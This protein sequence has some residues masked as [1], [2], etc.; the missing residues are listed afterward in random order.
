MRLPAERLPL[1]ALLFSA[2]L[3]AWSPAFAEEAAGFEGWYQIDIILFKPRSTDLDEESWQE[4]DNHYPHD[5]VS[6]ADPLPASLTQ[7]EQLFNEPL[8]EPLAEEPEALA[9]N[10]FAFKDQ[11][12]SEANRL[13]LES[14]TGKGPASA[15]PDDNPG[16]AP[17]AA[18]P[19]EDASDEPTT[20]AATAAS[21]TTPTAPVIDFTPNPNAP[22][23]VAFKRVDSDSSL[24]SILRSLRRSS[25]FTVIDQAS[26]I[27][28]IDEAPITV[29][30]QAGQRYDDTWE[31]EG[32]ISLTRSRFLHVD[33]DLWYTLFEPRGGAVDPLRT[34]GASLLNEVPEDFQGLVQELEQV[35]RERGQYYP[36]RQHTMV[37]SRRMRSDELH[38][39]DHPLFGL[40]IRVNRY[41]PPG[42][43]G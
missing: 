14:L 9:R 19:S 41:Q 36:A 26:W 37:Q 7:L 3:G 2:L 30:F 42:A 18:I 12:R 43:D 8:F 27:Q 39:L 6:V 23:Q 24:Q 5:V 20:P 35:E 4:P 31:L 15:V 25:S 10:E 11:S 32:T 1:T 22:G 28:P 38:Y 16:M 29:M 13:L 33:T 21:Q 34:S 17:P 40:L